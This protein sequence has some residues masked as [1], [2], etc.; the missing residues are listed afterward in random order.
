MWKIR[1]AIGIAIMTVVMTGGVL[2]TAK[3][4]T[5]IDAPVLVPATQPV[6]AGLVCSSSNYI[7]I[8]AKAL[9]MESAALRQALVGGKTLD[10]LA[11]AKHVAIQ[12][13]MTALNTTYKSDLDQALKDG[14][15]TQF[16][17]D[18]LKGTTGGSPTDIATATASSAVPGQLPIT[19]P[20]FAI[21]FVVGY[22]LPTP[23]N[24]VKP[25]VESAKALAMSCADLVKATRNDQSVAQVAVA[26]KVEPQKVIDALV[27]A[28]K[29]AI[30]DDLKEGLISQVEADLRTTDALNWAGLFVYQPNAGVGISLAATGTALL[31]A[32]GSLPR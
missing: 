17:Y 29:A 11:T 12:D 10:Q 9:G 22:P 13:V 2:G 14:L 18:Q 1:K 26:Q 16:E 6:Y 7:D 24:E 15:I 30:A 20:A 27:N 4:Q 23:F 31:P 8:A 5:P 25:F 3:A 28:R 21:A 32:S 19:K